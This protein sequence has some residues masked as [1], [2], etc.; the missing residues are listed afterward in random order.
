MSEKGLGRVKTPLCSSAPFNRPSF[1]L[2]LTVLSKLFQ[3]HDQREPLMQPRGFFV[4]APDPLV[5]RGSARISAYART[6]SS[7]FSTP[8]M[9]KTRVRL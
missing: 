9:F 4:D 8:T 1:C 6:A 3:M 2:G 5:T 7:S